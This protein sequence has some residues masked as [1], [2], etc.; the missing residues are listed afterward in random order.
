MVFHNAGINHVHMYISA[1][2]PF[3]ELEG[4]IEI[5]TALDAAGA[6]TADL[7]AV[8][9]NNHH[10]RVAPF[11]ARLPWSVAQGAYPKSY[12]SPLNLLPGVRKWEAALDVAVAS[13]DGLDLPKLKQIMAKFKDAVKRFKKL[14]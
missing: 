9:T 4:A 13:S 11:E 14:L 12:L 6:S 1:S 8:C 7:V 3:R 2:D 10:W 5:Q